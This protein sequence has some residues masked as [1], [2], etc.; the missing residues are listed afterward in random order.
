MSKLRVERMVLIV[1]GEGERQSKGA[2]RLERMPAAVAH[3][4]YGHLN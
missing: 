4:P 2:V 3:S 1:P